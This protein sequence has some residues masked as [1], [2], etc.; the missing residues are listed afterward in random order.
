MFGLNMHELQWQAGK[1]SIWIPPFLVFFLAIVTNSKLEIDKIP[2][3]SNRKKL[4]H[5]DPNPLFELQQD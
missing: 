1:N 2:R 3:Q 4:I 5:V